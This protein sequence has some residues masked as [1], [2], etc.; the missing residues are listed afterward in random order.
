MPNSEQDYQLRNLTQLFRSLI[1][2][3]DLGG[4]YI[5]NDLFFASASNPEGFAY[6]YPPWEKYVNFNPKER[7]WYKSHF[8]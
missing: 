4:E 6:Y 1:F 8:E 5:P 3:I 7:P 2:E